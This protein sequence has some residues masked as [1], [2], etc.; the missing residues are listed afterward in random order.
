VERNRLVVKRT[1]YPETTVCD[2]DEIEIVA[3]VGGG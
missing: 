2:G 3:F 1:N